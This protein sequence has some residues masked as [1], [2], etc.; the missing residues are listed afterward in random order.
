MD[1]LPELLKITLPAAL[2]LYAMYLTLRSFLNKNLLDRQVDLRAEAA[3]TLL[4]LRLQAYE[5]MVLFLERISPNNLLL[6][7]S[8]AAG[9][10][11]E[12]QQLLLS[13]IRDEFNH[14]LAQQVYLS[15][16]AWDRIRLAQNEV[17]GL[18]NSAAQDLPTDAPP[19]DLSRRI[20]DRWIT[21][22]PTPTDEA[23]RFLKDEVRREFM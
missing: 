20:F 7:L 8:P 22:S 18:V 9:S 23:L 17:L 12:L 1:L 13:D 5:R 19:L 16:E 4:P 3:R 15:N 2:V 21:L 14:N 6:R 10:A 11:L